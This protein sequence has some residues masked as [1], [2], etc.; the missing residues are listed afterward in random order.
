MIATERY[1][2][3]LDDIAPEMDFVKFERLKNIFAK[4]SIR[5]LIAVIPQNLDPKIQY[6]DPREDFWKLVLDLKKLGWLIAQHGFEHKFETQDGGILGLHKRSEFAGLPFEIQ[7]EKISKGLKILREKGIEAEI[8]VAPAHS[9]DEKT[10]EA[11]AA[12]GI[13]ILSD[14][15]ALYPFKRRGVLWLPQI[16]WQPRR[17]PLGLLTFV[18]HHNTM[19]ERDFERLEEFIR[20]HRQRIGNFSDLVLW[21][22][23]RNGLVIFLSAVANFI[24]RPLWK[25]AFRIKSK[26]AYQ[27]GNLEYTDAEAYDKRGESSILENYVLSLWQPF[28]KNK[29]REL[30]KG[31]V[32]LDWGCGTGE[33]ASAARQARKIYCLDISEAMLKRA[34]E[35]LKDLGQAEFICGSGFNKE[36]PAG[37]ADLV[38]TIGVWEYVVEQKLFEEL[39]RLTKPGS[40]VLVVSPNI[41]NQLNFLRSLA[42]FKLKALRPG[43]IRKLFSDDFRLVEKASFGMVGWFP[44]KLQFLVRPF[45][46]LT[47]WFWKPLQPY[48]PLGINIYYLFERK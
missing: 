39:K 45:W 25:L 20:A 37:I 40:L 48:L 16:T 1:F 21:Y 17:F 19:T 27:A 47:D 14:G 24:F 36:I 38:L 6:S 30:S 42:S 44:K 35:K 5:P 34:K 11:L 32:I 23:K 12:N 2:F 41:Y 33:Y 46:R 7:K 10:L 9:F 43:F 8:F 4:F 22:Q 13:K 3:R 26:S 29:V 28:L 31:K 15:I 18:L